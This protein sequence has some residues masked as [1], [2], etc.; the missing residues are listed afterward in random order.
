[1][2]TIFCSVSTMTSHD[3]SQLLSSFFLIEHH[4]LHFLS[5]F[6]LVSTNSVK[7]TV[8]TREWKK[9]QKG[10]SLKSEGRKM[11]PELEPE[12]VTLLDGYEDKVRNRMVITKKK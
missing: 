5:P 4:S 10:G 8:S 1:M 9:K 11:G 6:F 2:G 3:L 7:F 12:R